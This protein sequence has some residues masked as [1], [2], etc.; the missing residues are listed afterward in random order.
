MLQRHY[1]YSSTNTDFHPSSKIDDSSVTIAPYISAYDRLNFE[2]LMPGPPGS[3]IPVDP[4]KNTTNTTD[5]NSTSSDTNS[6]TNTTPSHNPSNFM[7]KEKITDNGTTSSKEASKNK[8]NLIIYIVAGIGVVI[9]II[10]LILCVCKSKNYKNSHRPI[11][12]ME[13]AGEKAE[14]LDESADKSGNLLQ[15]DTEG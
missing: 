1:N 5:T 14:S 10:L 12:D 9:L 11:V 8:T 15:G 4:T 6:T 3:P 2:G 7:P 13:V